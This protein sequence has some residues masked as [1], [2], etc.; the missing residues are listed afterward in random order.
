MLVTLMTA[1]SRGEV[2]REMSVWTAL[3]NMKAAMVGS[4]ASS[5]AEPCPP[6]PVMTRSQP[7]AEV[8]Q[9]PLR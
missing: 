7:S 9:G 2:S 5:G 6:L 1:V 4:M 8:M 3:P